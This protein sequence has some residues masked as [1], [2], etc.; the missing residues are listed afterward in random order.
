[1]LMLVYIKPDRAKKQKLGG[2]IATVDRSLH[3]RKK[4]HLYL[5]VPRAISFFF[6]FCKCCEFLSLKLK[7]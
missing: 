1:M 4:S 7:F 5:C 6:F 2:S 3:I